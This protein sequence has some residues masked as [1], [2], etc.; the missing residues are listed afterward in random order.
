[1]N[2][3]GPRIKYIRKRLGCNQDEFAKKLNLR[4]KQS[5]SF[6]ELDKTF[7]TIDTLAEIAKMGEVT[8]DW[9][10]VGERNQNIITQKNVTGSIAGVINGDAIL[11]NNNNNN[12]NDNNNNNSAGDLALLKRKNKLLEEVI[13]QKDS[14]I[15]QYEKLSGDKS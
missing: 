12:N 14:I 2:S 11:N 10:L 13:E 7:P 5:I 1:M 9:L 3:L 6:Y 8:M 15:R 4:N